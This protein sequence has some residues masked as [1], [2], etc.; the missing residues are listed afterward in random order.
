MELLVRC[1]DYNKKKCRDAGCY[2]SSSYLS[3][4]DGVY[5]HYPQSTWD[6]P[7]G[8]EDAKI[9]EYRNRITC[10]RYNKSVIIKRYLTLF[11]F[12]IDEII[13][14]HKEK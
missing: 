14:K 2:W 1:L 3:K 11:E 10:N 6:S 12:Y 13:E 5:H 8:K 7:I 9:D 4:D